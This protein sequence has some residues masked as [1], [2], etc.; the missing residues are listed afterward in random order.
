[1]L[2]ALPSQNTAGVQ[3]SLIPCCLAQLSG[4]FDGAADQW[5][6]IH[7]TAAVQAGVV[8]VLSLPLQASNGFSYNFQDALL[9]LTT[10][11]FVGV[12]STEGTWTAS[13]STAQL[14]VVLEDEVTPIVGVQT[15]GS[16]S[17]PVNH[18]TVFSDPGGSHALLTLYVQNNT[19][20]IVYI[21]IGTIVVATPQGKVLTV[22]ANS[23][24]TFNFGPSGLQQCNVYNNITSSGCYIRAYTNANLPFAQWVASQSTDTALLA[25]FL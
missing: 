13:A 9:T 2:T 17:V 25:T 22:A 24:T 11:L 15:I 10:G 23:T 1:M 20:A 4:Y 14:N 16:S 19:S 12:S 5:L 21:V 7:D 18:L 6:Q 8:P 3:L